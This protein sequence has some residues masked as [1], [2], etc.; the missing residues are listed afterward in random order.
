[1]LADG[2]RSFVGTSIPACV[3]VLLGLPALQSLRLRCNAGA[4]GVPSKSGF[5]GWCTHLPLCCA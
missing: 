5:T 4:P 2:R 3:D 1:M